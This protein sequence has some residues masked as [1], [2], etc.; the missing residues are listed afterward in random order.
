MKPESKRI[1]KNIENI[2]RGLTGTDLEI[3]ILSAENEMGKTLTD[4]ENNRRNEA[5][6]NKLKSVKSAQI[7]PL[8]GNFGGTDENSF[9]VTGVDL[10]TLKELSKEFN[11]MAF[12]YGRGKSDNMLFQYMEIKDVNGDRDYDSVQVRRTFI[13]KPNAEENFSEYKGVKFVIPFFDDDYVD[14]KWDDLSPLERGE[15][16]EISSDDEDSPD[17]TD[18]DKDKKEHY[19][20]NRISRL[21]ESLKEST[22]EDVKIKV[23]HSDLLEIPEG[24]KFWNMPFKHYTSLVE[25]KGYSKVIRALNN[26]S[27]WNKNDN[28]EISTKAENLMDKLKSKFREGK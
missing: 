8:Q 11:Q 14:L 20:I 9:L 16:V 10:Q 18:S 28:P 22:K 17:D 27:V 13:Y 7:F 25:R 4:S 26:I 5:L 23:K 19:A 15:T 2:L 1:F 24:R 12:I 21:I 6:L 3:G